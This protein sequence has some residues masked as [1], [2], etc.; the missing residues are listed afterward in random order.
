MVTAVVALGLE[1]V[2][3]DLA[4]ATSSQTVLARDRRAALLLML[5]AGLTLGLTL[6]VAFGL[7]AGV[8]FSLLLGAGYTGWP[9]YLLPRGWLAVHHHL[10]WSLMDFLSDA[11]QRGVLR[12]VGAVYQFRHIELQHRLANRDSG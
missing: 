12:Q 3:G 4:E 11:H 2:P 9:S 10:P 1:G 7:V 5:A 6:G 8:A